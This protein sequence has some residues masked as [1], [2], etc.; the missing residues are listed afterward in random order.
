VEQED[1]PAL[2]NLDDETVAALAKNMS[3]GFCEARLMWGETGVI[4]SPNFPQPYGS[5]MD[6]L[7]LL[8]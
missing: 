8:R 3:C 5:N 2:R 4:Q 1:P 7:W 6:C